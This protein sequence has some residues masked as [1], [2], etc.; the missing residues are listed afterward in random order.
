MATLSHLPHINNVQAGIDHWDPVNSAVYEVYFTL[1]EA[2]SIENKATSQT[3]LTEQII[4]VNGLDAIQKTTGQGQQ[5][6]FGVD[7]SFQNPMVDNTYADFQIALNLNLRNV[8]DNWVLKV[9]RAWSNLNYDLSSGARH[10]KADYCSNSV[11]ISQANR[12]GTV[13][14]T[15]NFYHVLLTKLDGMD[16]LNYTTNEAVTLNASFRAD[17][18]TEVME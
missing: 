8:T 9:F 3:L 14:R 12:D 15:I 7:V 6:F 1:P 16:T 10:L 4:S 17:N 5:K 18:W 13:W 2:L 11:K